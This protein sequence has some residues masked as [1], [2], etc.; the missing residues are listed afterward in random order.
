MYGLLKSNNDMPAIYRILINYKNG[1]IYSE[2][3]AVL[4]IHLLYFCSQ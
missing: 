2:D 1:N 3:F 4:N